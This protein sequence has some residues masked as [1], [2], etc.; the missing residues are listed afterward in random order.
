MS[1]SGYEP[2][3]PGCRAGCESL[4]AVV[5]I[6][7][8]WVTFAFLASEQSGLPRAAAVVGSLVG[9]SIG[10]RLRE[11]ASAP[12][13]Y[14][15][16][17]AIVAALALVLGG[18]VGEH[19]WPCFALGLFMLGIVIGAGTVAFIMRVRALWRSGS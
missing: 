15:I 4:A 7:D 6:G 3:A 17:F 14:L 8:A 13:S 19:C 11:R 10:V 16:P 1:N 12:L 5:F 2:G 18:L 9:L